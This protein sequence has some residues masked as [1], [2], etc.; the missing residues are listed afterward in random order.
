[1]ILNSIKSSNIENLVTQTLLSSVTNFSI[2]GDKRDQKY[3]NY[4]STSGGGRTM[5]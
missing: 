2:E 4:E 5:P 1:M 3:A